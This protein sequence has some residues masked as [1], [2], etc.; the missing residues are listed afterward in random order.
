MSINKKPVNRRVFIVAGAGFEPA[1]SGLWA[2]RSFFYFIS[3]CDDGAPIY[4]TNQKPRYLAGIE[5]YW[6]YYLNT[7]LTSCNSLY[8]SS[9]L[10]SQLDGSG[11]ARIRN[12]LMLTWIMDSLELISLMTSADGA[13]SSFRLATAAALPLKILF[14][15]SSTF[16]PASRNASSTEASTPTRL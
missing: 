13:L 16:I 15:I 3:L 4:T 5:N 12:Y 7:T 6:M 14:S 2:S 1:T 9:C 11:K 8:R 10:S